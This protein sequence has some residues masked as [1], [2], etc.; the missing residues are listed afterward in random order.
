MSVSDPRSP[1]RPLVLG[2]LSIQSRLIVGTG[3]YADYPTMRACHEAAGT[4]LVT[5]ALRRVD[6]SAPRGSAILDY[7][8]R[9]RIHLLPNT[10]GCYT[11]EEAITTAHLARELLGT[12]LLK[13]EV[14]GDPDTLFPDVEGTLE[15][16][17]DDEDISDPCTEPGDTGLP[18][19]RTQ[20]GVEA[21]RDERVTLD[22]SD[23]D[24][25]LEAP[26]S[27]EVEPLLTFGPPSGGAGAAS[28]GWHGAIRSSFPSR[29]PRAPVKYSLR[30]SSILS[31]FRFIVRFPLY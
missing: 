4:Q 6:L 3:K 22:G 21:E 2:S 7:V 17:E 26:D 27:E 23:I 19:A 1:D 15:A 12:S 24:D 14:I 18:T 11:P 25:L 13:L 5:V 9:N 20:A 8:D 29:G 28:S 10:A 30:S 16:D 31:F